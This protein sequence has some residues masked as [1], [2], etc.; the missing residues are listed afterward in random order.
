MKSVPS[1]I[2]FVFL[3]V[4]TPYYFFNHVSAETMYASVATPSVGWITGWKSPE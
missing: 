3:V 2:S 4:P 1:N